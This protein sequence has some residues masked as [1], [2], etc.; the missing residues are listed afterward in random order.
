MALADQGAATV[1]LE[2]N[3]TAQAV[4]D[5]INH[6]LQDKKVYT[7]MHDAQVKIAVPDCAERMCAI[8]ENLISGNAHQ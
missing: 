7:A 5:E 3:C 4:M 1:I 2:K 8:M 6:L